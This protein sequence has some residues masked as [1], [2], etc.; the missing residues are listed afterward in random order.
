M[1]TTMGFARL[2]ENLKEECTFACTNRIL[3]KDK[4]FC[5]SVNL[6]TMGLCLFRE[7]LQNPG[8]IVI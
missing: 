7:R 2:V 6:M 1:Y 3:V 5:K 8:G 4:S